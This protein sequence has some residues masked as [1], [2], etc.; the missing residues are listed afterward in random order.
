MHGRHLS[1]FMDEDGWRVAAARLDPQREGKPA[2]LDFKFRRRDGSD[3]WAHVSASPILADD[4]SY[5]GSLALIT[6]I[7][8]RKSAEAELARLAWHDA[9]TGLANRSQLMERIGDAL[10][11]QARTAGMVALLFLDLDQFK[12]VNDSLGH[13]AGDQVLAQVADRLRGVDPRHRHRRP[14]R[15]R[16]VRH[17]RRA[18][19][20]RGGSDRTRRADP[21]RAR[22]P[23]GGLRARH[24]HHRQYRHRHGRPT[25]RTRAG[26]TRALRRARRYG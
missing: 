9:L 4:G 22:R 20:R 19:R 3:L 25:R 23:D 1:E 16:R 11:R 17:R 15:R 26:E 8:A 2:R 6:D 14:T 7:T 24:R 5:L 13:A 21:Q 10:T 12:A 18:P